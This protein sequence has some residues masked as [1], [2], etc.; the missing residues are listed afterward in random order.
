MGDRVAVVIGGE[1]KQVDT[2]KKI[3]R[4]ADKSVSF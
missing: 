1:L 2:P 3:K 4:P